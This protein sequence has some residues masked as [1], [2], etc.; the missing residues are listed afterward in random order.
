MSK[1]LFFYLNLIVLKVVS[2]EPLLVREDSVV[3]EELC[4]V[5]PRAEVQVEVGLVGSTDY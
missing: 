5:V 3:P 4:S 1:F 2:E